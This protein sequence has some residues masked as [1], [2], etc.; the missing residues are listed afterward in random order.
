MSWFLEIKL[1]YLKGRKK[2]KINQVQDNN[3]NITDIQTRFDYLKYKIM[4]YSILYIRK[5]LEIKDR[6]KQN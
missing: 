5:E 4:K 3:S 6:K 1:K 2:H